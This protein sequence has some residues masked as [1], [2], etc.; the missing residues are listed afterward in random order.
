MC[1]VIHFIVNMQVKM[2]FYTFFMT[3]KYLTMQVNHCDINK[4]DGEGESLLS[5]SAIV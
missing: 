3:F 1:V 5:V 4:N 2:F